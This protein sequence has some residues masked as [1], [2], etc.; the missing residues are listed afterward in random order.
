MLIDNSSIWTA[1]PFTLCPRAIKW[2]ARVRCARMKFWTGE[3][4]VMI[5][6]GLLLIFMRSPIECVNLINLSELSLFNKREITRPSYTKKQ[7]WQRLSKQMFGNFNPFIIVNVFIASRIRYAADGNECL[8]AP[9]AL[10][11]ADWWMRQGETRRFLDARLIY[12]FH[13]PKVTRHHSLGTA[14]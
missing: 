11:N 8:C 3:Y 7:P 2:P 13:S 12:N 1:L 14:L 9:R 5:K 6:L 10:V 4:E